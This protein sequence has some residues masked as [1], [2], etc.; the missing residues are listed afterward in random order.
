LEKYYG[1]K[2][3]D[4]ALVSAIHL[5]S[6][7]L[8]D[9]FMPEKA[10]DLLDQSVANVKIQLTSKPAQILDLEEKKQNLFLQQQMIILE[11]TITS[12]NKSEQ[13]QTQ[14]DKIQEDLI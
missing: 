3:T 12:K 14:I 6:K 13:L 2:I 5:S 10:I 7:Y 9:K 4:E 11:N 8:Q 1:V